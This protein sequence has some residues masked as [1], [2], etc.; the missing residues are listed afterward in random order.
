MKRRLLAPMIGAALFGAVALG[1]EPGSITEARE[2]LGRGSNDTFSLLIPLV[3][4]TFFISKILPAEDTVTLAGGILGVRIQSDSIT[5]NV[6]EDL[7]FDNIV[8]DQFTFSFDDMLRTEQASTNVAFPT[9]AQGP[10]AP[11]GAAFVPGQPRDTISF[12]TPGGSNVR[13]ATVDSGLAIRTMT[14]NTVCP[15]TVNISLVDSLGATVVTFPPN[16]ALGAN[17]TVVD[18]ASMSGARLSGFIDISTT[19]TFGACVPSFGSNVASAITFPPMTL[20]SVDLTNVNETFNENYGALDSE[21][22]IQAIDT[23]VGSGGSLNVVVQNRL[24]MP[25]AV[26]MTMNGILG[27]SGA[28]LRDSTVVPAAPGDGTTTS[29]TLVF[30]LAGASIISASVRA[31]VIGR[32][33]AASATVIPAAATDAAVVDGTGNIVVER[34]AGT[35]DPARTPELTIAVEEFTALDASAIDFDDLNDAMRQSTINRATVDL[36]ITNGAD[37]PLVLSG[38]TLGVVQLDAA[39]AIRRDAQGNPDYEVDANGADLTVPVADSGQTDLAVAP[40]GSRAISLNAAPLVDRMVKLALGGTDAALLT[41]GN[42]IAGDGTTPG[43]ISSGDKVGV[44]FDVTVGLDFTLPAG[45]I[46]FD[47]N[48]VSDGI[49]LDSA[50]ADDLASRVVDVG[51]TA[52]AENF[53]PFGLEVTVAIA[54]DSLADSVDVFVQANAIFLDTMALAAPTVDAQGIPQGTTTDSIAVGITGQEVRVLFGKFFTAGI[55]IRLLAGT[56][57][58]GRGAIRTGDKIVISAAAL[59][60]IRRGGN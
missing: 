9:P 36:T 34:L 5:V 21:P 42:V 13:G 24:P 52:S 19:A 56:G 37:I 41:A 50:D 40:L 60:R 8:F 3:S 30:P 2:Q 35:L 14:N 46:Q 26:D 57:G 25:L 48:Q 6:G 38:L 59:I 12:L 1:C 15:A 53:T 55:R 33:T 7:K 39:G 54:P 47:I 28:P 32:A 51:G 18:T 20:A 58:G 10:A 44:G 29:A 27:P 43:S 45:G 16:V 49:D 22:R 31:N 17:V 4:D 11:A 23:I